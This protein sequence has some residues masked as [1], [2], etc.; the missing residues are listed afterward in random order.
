MV[1]R[2]VSLSLVLLLTF[3]LVAASGAD[4][5]QRKTIF[6]N[7]T[8]SDTWAAGMALGQASMALKKWLRSGRLS[9]RA[10]CLSGGQVASSGYLQRYR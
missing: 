8:T 5:P 1:H 10:R 9:Q 7:V 4:E 6:Y 2:V 3:V